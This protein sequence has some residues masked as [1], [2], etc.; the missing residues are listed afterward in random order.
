MLAFEPLG[1]LARS[2]F[3]CLRLQLVSLGHQPIKYPL[4]LA[5]QLGAH[6]QLA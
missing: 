3:E 5:H 2:D 4:W 1:K 6:P